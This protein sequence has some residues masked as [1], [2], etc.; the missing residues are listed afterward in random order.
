METYSKFWNT[1]EG[2]QR[3]CEATTK[4]FGILS[5]S[6]SIRNKKE[7]EFVKVLYRCTYV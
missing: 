6:V 7:Y 4:R 3:F 2:D 1:T 5:S